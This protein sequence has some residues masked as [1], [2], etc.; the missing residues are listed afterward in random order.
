M[1]LKE[2]NDLEK[3][4]L[5]AAITVAIIGVTPSLLL[6]LIAEAKKQSSYENGL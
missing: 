2:L 1:T 4:I 5:K 3:S 6:R